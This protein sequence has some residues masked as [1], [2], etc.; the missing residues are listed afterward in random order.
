MSAF[1]VSG[2]VYDRFM[3]R[4][5]VPLALVFADFAGVGPPMRVADVGA[6][7][8]AL[9]GELVRRLGADR[10]G[11]ADPSAQFVAAHRKRFREVDAQE[12]PAERL[13]W[14][15]DEFDAALAQ[16]VL[17]FVHDP[18][19][20]AAEMRR[21]VRPGGVVAA[22]M[23]D[24]HGMEMLRITWESVKAID[25]DA[26]DESGM[27]FQSE[28]EL[29]ELFEQAGFADVATGPLDVIASYEDFEDIWSA[30]LGGAGPA[31]A[32]AVSLDEE[33]R[34]ALRDEFHSRLGNPTGSFRLPARAW[35]V[36]GR[37]P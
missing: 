18:D 17:R 12:A 25:P 36:R 15:D 14:G 6:G 23:W 11:A 30:L 8:G 27:P 7:T 35:A 19:A 20:A 33:R 26:T 28:P 13:P 1:H 22:C 10:V 21:V 9:T 5:S 2:D 37:V 4:F 31:G 29:R 32:Y 16:L 34:A 3:G 24:G